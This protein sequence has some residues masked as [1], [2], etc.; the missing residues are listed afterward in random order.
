MTCEDVKK[1][2]KNAI[3][4]IGILFVIIGVIGSLWGNVGGGAVSVS[5]GFIL[6]VFG[7]IEID[8]IHEFNFFNITFKLREKLNEAEKIVNQMRSVLIPLCSISIASASLELKEHKGITRRSLYEH[9]ADIEKS[10]IE[11]KTPVEIIEDM[12]AAYYNAFLYCMLEDVRDYTYKIFYPI[13]QEYQREKNEI[14]LKYKQELSNYTVLESSIIDKE[15]FRILEVGS[16]GL[17]AM[18]VLRYQAKGA[19][20]FESYKTYIYS[21]DALNSEVKE[22]IVEGMKPMLLDI[23]EYVKTHK[24]K[25]LEEF[26]NKQQIQ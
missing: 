17:D 3:Y 14:L 25:S 13:Q 1:S 21:I 18:Q 16:I 24:I 5:A 10:L 7:L 20:H 12:K 19:S 26:L 4:Y 6:F 22:K 23:D 11:V 9:V 2:N 8:N 15:K